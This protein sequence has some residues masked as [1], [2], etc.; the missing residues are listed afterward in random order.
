MVSGGGYLVTIHEKNMGD[1][2]YFIDSLVKNRPFLSL[3]LVFIA[4][5]LVSFTPC[6]YPL[7]PV[8]LGVIGIDKETSRK[9][10]FFLSATY[11]LGL[12]SI[13]TI[14][15]VISSLSGN[16]FGE[17]TKFAPL[18]FIAAVI[19]FFMGLVLLD[20]LNLPLNFSLNFRAK[21]TG[22]LGVFSL[23]VVSGLVVGGCT[24]PVLGSILTLIAFGK[25]VFLGGLLLFVFS[26]G[27]GVIFIAVAVFGAGAL[28]FLKK[29]AVFLL[30]IKKFFGFMLILISLYFL[31]R[32]FSLL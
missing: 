11:V 15:G 7:I 6:S 10:A 14:L 29:R 25:D 30:W 22:Y 17:W 18:Q 8:I 21:K 28:S 23:G 13:Y 26:L 20:V 24:F 32:G 16:I 3:P 5:V 1:F 19:F 4:G 12:A 2:I 27:L 31:I 9:K